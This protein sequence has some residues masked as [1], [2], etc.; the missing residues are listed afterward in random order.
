MRSCPIVSPSLYIV[1]RETGSRGERDEGFGR[2]KD[3]SSEGC[4]RVSCVLEGSGRE[5]ESVVR[6]VN[7][8]QFAL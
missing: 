1:E 7:N 4:V 8:V 6:S 3:E 5:D 2:S